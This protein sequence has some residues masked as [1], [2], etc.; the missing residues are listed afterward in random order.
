[1][2]LEF[3]EGGLYILMCS[4]SNITSLTK[5]MSLRKKSDHL[6]QEGIVA[7]FPYLVK[8]ASEDYTANV[9]NPGVPNARELGGAWITQ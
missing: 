1:M 9:V 7:H 5:R 3:L 8:S 6:Y 4:N 2:F